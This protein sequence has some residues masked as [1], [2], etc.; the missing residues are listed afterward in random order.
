MERIDIGTV[1]RWIILGTFGFL[2]ISMLFACSSQKAVTKDVR[3]ESHATQQEL[4]HN[5]QYDSV[6]SLLQHVA[7]SQIKRDSVVIRDSVIIRDSIVVTL[8]QSGVLLHKERYRDRS[9]T[10]DKSRTEAEQQI[11]TLRSELIQMAEKNE[12]I[13]SEYNATKNLLSDYEEKL[14]KKNNFGIVMTWIFVIIIEVLCTI[15]AYL[16]LKKPKNKT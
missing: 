16:S 8:D 5:T 2:T 15:I 7:D 12:R 13:E 4:R 10:S 3:I 14:K 1:T 11:S 9:R 6:S